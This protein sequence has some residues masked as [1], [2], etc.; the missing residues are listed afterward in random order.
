[1]DKYT[2]DL[3]KLL[4]DFEYNELTDTQ[5][6]TST[7]VTAPRSTDINVQLNNELPATTSNP[8]TTNAK[9][10]ITNV[11]HSLNEY[12]ST[13]ISSIPKK[14]DNIC[15]NNTS[16]KVYKSSNVAPSNLDKALHTSVVDKVNPII[17]GKIDAKEEHSD[18]Q[19]DSSLIKSIQFK[20][21]ELKPE[22]IT[23]KTT[24]LLNENPYKPTTEEILPF[25][26]DT[27]I[28]L[29]DE[30]TEK[31]L[32]ESVTDEK[33]T[34]QEENSNSETSAQCT[35]SIETNP[36]KNKK[37]E[38]ATIKTEVV[39]DDIVLTEL[40]SENDEPYKETLTSHNENV[41]TLKLLDANSDVVNDDLEKPLEVVNEKSDELHTG[42]LEYDIKSD[43]VIKEEQFLK[44]DESN[45]ENVNDIAIKTDTKIDNNND[46]LI[47]EKLLSFETIEFDF[48]DVDEFLDRYEEE[49][50]RERLKEEIKIERKP[51]ECKV[52]KT[53]DKDEEEVSDEET[54][55][56]EPDEEIRVE[57]REKVEEENTVVSNRNNDNNKGLRIDGKGDEEIIRDEEVPQEK[58]QQPDANKNV[59]EISQV[60]VA[61]GDGNVIDN[62]SETSSIESD[63]VN[64][65]I[66]MME[67]DERTTENDTIDAV[68]QDKDEEIHRGD[69]EIDVTDVV[70][71][72]NNGDRPTSLELETNDSKREIDLIGKKR[73]C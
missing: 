70:P 45:I 27:D 5:D 67:S 46:N 9:H 16:N 40:I 19:D 61:D 29:H 42:N 26:D 8:K 44:G 13:D 30:L 33:N 47:K 57:Q 50:D 6:T 23:E 24:N 34:L 62:K 69:G 59:T 64:E 39:R 54:D 48:G 71:V 1:M 17:L 43:D 51:I 63:I 2:V 72:S 32:N 7:T 41:E 22:Y 65:E 37:D 4:N 18:L 31:I 25:K 49:Y 21:E 66:T 15:V 53:M 28:R 12:I 11:F 73:K 58:N 36:E 14:I 3:D 55:I 38:E 68:K 35:D 20:A 56:I 52:G 60:E 10:S